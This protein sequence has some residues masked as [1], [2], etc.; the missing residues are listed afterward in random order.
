ML[1]SQKTVNSADALIKYI[2]RRTNLFGF[3][4][5]QSTFEAFFSFLFL[6]R[7]WGRGEVGLCSGK[8][9][10]KTFYVES[11]YPP[12]LY[13]KRFI[14]M[15]IIPSSENLFIL[16]WPFVDISV[17]SF[18][19]RPSSNIKNTS[20]ASMNDSQSYSRTHEDRY[21]L[22]CRDFCF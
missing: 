10:H 13:A 1:S 17:T 16:I 5:S 18:T 2:L 19:R 22:N 7:G 4:V 15:K 14:L 6:L 8:G 11:Q 12:R 9:K 3:A 20:T 21:F